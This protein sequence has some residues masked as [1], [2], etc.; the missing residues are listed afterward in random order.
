MSPDVVSHRDSRHPDYD[1]ESDQD[2]TELTTE[3]F[4]ATSNATV[5]HV[6]RM[7]GGA[8][9]HPRWPRSDD[10][11]GLRG[12]A[13]GDKSVSRDALEHELLLFTQIGG[14]IISSTADRIL[15]LAWTADQK[16]IRF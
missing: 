12:Q 6:G 16:S 14:S 10:G 15:V 3:C 7:R 13:F 9:T 11:M 2:R 4:A 1:R 8:S 5:H